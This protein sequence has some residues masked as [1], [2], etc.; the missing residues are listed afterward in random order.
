[1]DK[2]NKNLESI[3]GQLVHIENTN[4]G[5]Y[6]QT[7]GLEQEFREIIKKNELQVDPPL[8]SAELE[9]LTNG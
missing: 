7:Q 5:L 6:K 4:L 3:K 2:V 9:A 1:M 8:N